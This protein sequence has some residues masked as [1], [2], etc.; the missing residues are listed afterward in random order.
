MYYQKG[1]TLLELL[2]TIA[3]IGI[4]ITI[5]APSMLETQKSI[6]LKGAV[7]VNYFAF[8]QARSE[9]ISAGAD[10]TLSF[11]AG[12]NWCVAISDVGDCDCNT[13]NACT[14][15]GV[16]Q[17]VKAN[18]FTNITM[19][20]LNF[21]ADSIATF[22]GIRG[23]SLGSAGS[24]VLSDGTNEARLVLSNMGRARICMQAGTLGNYAAC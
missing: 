2:V 11:T 13:A 4:V 15:N 18:D 16:E 14:I 6:K 3:I 23:L 10:V 8:Q 1:L 17:I 19:E 12:T 20:N 7:E 24:T 22:D 9:A 5:G 21:G